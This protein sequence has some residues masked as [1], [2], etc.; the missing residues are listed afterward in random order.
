MGEVYEL[1]SY[2]RDEQVLGIDEMY[3]G[4]PAVHYTH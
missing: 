2:S 1:A 3:D 4:R